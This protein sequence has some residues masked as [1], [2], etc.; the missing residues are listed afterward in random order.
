MTIGKITSSQQDLVYV[1]VR[2]ETGVELE[3]RI[4]G[5][6]ADISSEG[7][8]GQEFTA[9]HYFG[10]IKI[11]V[12]STGTSS[13]VARLY[14]SHQK[15]VKYHET[16]FREVGQDK[17]LH[18][19][20]DPLPPSMY[21]WELEVWSGASLFKLYGYTGSTYG[22]CYKDGVL[23]SGTDL[24]SKVVYCEDTEV[25][26]PVAVVGDTVDSGVTTVKTGSPLG[27]I[28]VGV[29]EK[30][31]SRELDELNNGGMIMTGSWFMEMDD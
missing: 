18:W 15:Q 14:D 30:N 3:T 22:G 27:Q 9:A 20:F 4:G 5:M 25:E 31:I 7:T 26:R 19:A 23:L 21:Y 10:R 28:M 29:V 2:P 6:Q 8:L 17:V 12:K 11:A 1:K 24:M 13:L 16:V